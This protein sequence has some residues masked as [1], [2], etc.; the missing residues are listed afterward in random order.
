MNITTYSRNQNLEYRPHMIVNYVVDICRFMDGK[1]GNKFMDFLEGDLKKFS[2]I[3]H[4]CP[5]VVSVKLM[6]RFRFVLLTLPSICKKGHFYL[7]NMTFSDEIFPS[8]LPAAEVFV[9]FQYYIYVNGL[10]KLV[11]YYRPYLEVKT[12]G[13]EYF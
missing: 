10:A 6:K 2:N 5:Y 8:M 13:I 1:L 7:R 3:I 11:H 9:D 12:K 4:P